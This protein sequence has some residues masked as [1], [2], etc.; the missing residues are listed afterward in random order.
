MCI[1]LI[2]KVHLSVSSLHLTISLQM[3]EMHDVAISLSQSHGNKTHQRWTFNI[4]IPVSSWS[5]SVLYINYLFT[6]RH[7]ES[8]KTKTKR[9]HFPCYM[10]LTVNRNESSV[11]PKDSVLARYGTIIL[12]H[13]NMKWWYEMHHKTSV[14]NR[15]FESVTDLQCLEIRRSIR[16][17]HVSMNHCVWGLIQCTLRCD[18]KKIKNKNLWVVCARCTQLCLCYKNSSCFWT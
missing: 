6:K 16:M 4:T 18:P 9:W 3:T 13:I 10:K 5:D 15:H 1:I 14:I 12:T 2:D 11:S 17:Q 8:W 7:Q